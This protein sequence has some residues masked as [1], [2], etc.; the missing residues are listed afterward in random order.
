MFSSYRY[1]VPIQ[2]KRMKI[3]VRYDISKKLTRW[4]NLV[5]S[6]CWD[7]KLLSWYHALQSWSQDALAEVLSVVLGWM[8]S[9]I[10]Q[11]WLSVVVG[12]QKLFYCLS[13]NK[14]KCISRGDCAFLLPCQRKK[15]RIPS[16]TPGAKFDWELA[17]SVQLRKV[18]SAEIPCLLF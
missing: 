7:L 5:R 15:T 18:T 16:L 17:Y 9:C 3:R 6:A 4:L 10:N 8:N 13:D 11:S 12:F 2:S 14:P 1:P